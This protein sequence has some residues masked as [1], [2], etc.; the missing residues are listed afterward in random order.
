[1]A[2]ETHR[3]LVLIAE[4]DRLQGWRRE[5]FASWPQGALIST[6]RDPGP[7]LRWMG[8][9]VLPREARPITRAVG[10]HRRWRR[11]RGCGPTRA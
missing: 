7:H 2:A 9:R 5:G 11:A 3:L 4:F 10:P 6:E 8:C 1:V